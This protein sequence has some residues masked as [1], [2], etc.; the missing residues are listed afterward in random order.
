MPV[1]SR[2]KGARGELLW[3]DVLRSKGLTA[4]RGQ[5][6]CGANGDSDVIC[7]E[8][9]NIHFEVKFVQNFNA[10][11]A[12]EQAK[13]DAKD[14]QMPVVVQKST[15]KDWIAVMDAEELLDMIVSLNSIKDLLRHPIYTGESLKESIERKLNNPY[16]SPPSYIVTCG[17]GASI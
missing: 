9:S 2:A 5:Q 16:L 8:L 14:G 10:R 6:F 1:N 17:K 11:K 4:R 7:E 15:N 13:S 3:R 12:L